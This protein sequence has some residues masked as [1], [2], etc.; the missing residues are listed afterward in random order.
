MQNNNF[1]STWY[2]NYYS[3]VAI[4]GITP[5]EHYKRVGKTIGRFRNLKELAANKDFAKHATRFCPDAYKLINPDL[6]LSEISPIAHYSTIGLKENRIGNWLDRYIEIKYGK[7]ERIRIS[8]LIN[9]LLSKEEESFCDLEK[10]LKRGLELYKIDLVEEPK[11]TIIIPVYNQLKYTLACLISLFESNPKTPFEV[12]IAD[13]CSM[14]KTYETLSGVSSSIKIVRTSGNLGFL[15]NCNNAAK[16]AKGKILVFLNNDMVVFL[17]WLDQ[18]VDTLLEDE[19]YGMIGSKLLNLN[20]TLQEA[21]GILW[22]DGSAW[23][24]GRNQDPQMSEFNY[25]KEVDY[26]SGAS[27][28]IYKNVW[29]SVGGF[30]EIYTP[31]YCEESDLSFRLREIGLK[32]IYQPCSEGVHLEGVSCGTETTSGIKSFQVVNSKK[33]VQR[34]D[35]ILKQNHFKN[36]ENVFFARDKSHGRKLM[37]VVD[38][39]IPQPDRDA[40]SKT[41]EHFLN[42][43]LSMGYN[44]KFIADNWHYDKLYAR[45]LERKGIEVIYDRDPVSYVASNIAHADIIFLSRPEVA[46]RYFASIINNSAKVVYYG[47][48]I[49]HL[50]MQQQLTLK[51]DEELQKRKNEILE[52]EKK[53]WEKSD[54]VLYP[55]IDEA[56]VVKKHLAD[57]KKEK[58]AYKIQPWSYTVIEQRNLP[59]GN[60]IIFVAGFAHPPNIDAAKWFIDGAWNKVK[61][62]HHEIKLYL[63]GSNPSDE[64]V[65][66]AENNIIVTGYVTDDELKR[67]YLSARLSIAPLMYG[68]GVKG[69]VIESLSYGVPVV[70]TSVGAQGIDIEDSGLLVGNHEDE[71]AD[72]IIQLIEQGELW[73]NISKIGL[74]FIKQNYSKE[75]MRHEFESILENQI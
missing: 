75:S 62:H 30:D 34:W 45:K 41:M 64:I 57:Q 24:Y 67:Y 56:N 35:S 13:D 20:G 39:Y 27:L 58:S 50:R 61:L 52:L 42:C 51:Y 74:N 14:D 53:V 26:C 3:D 33:F 5:E 38:H 29:A 1:D 48:D 21:G 31:A 25:K 47:H 18:L 12:I 10:R 7:N 68:A 69:K 19:T 23:N 65:S 16:F 73:S 72:H 28:C 49:H 22:N 2:S 36:G 9:S 43:F 4:S 17:E 60:D 54:I 37:L 6:D 11:V 44:I 32:T 59:K 70:T 55:S 40:G 8:S 46:V 66:L 71:F 15:R 63:I